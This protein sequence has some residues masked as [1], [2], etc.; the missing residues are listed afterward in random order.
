MLMNQTA[1]QPEPNPLREG[2]ATRPVPQPCSIVIFGA[3]GDLA[4]RKLVPALYNVAADGEL[5]LRAPQYVE[6]VYLIDVEVAD[7]ADRYV[8]DV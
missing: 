7:A 1:D 6:D 4:H 3:T 8:A 2:L 5:L